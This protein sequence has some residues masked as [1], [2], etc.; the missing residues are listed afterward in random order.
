LFDLDD[1]QQMNK[2]DFG[3]MLKTLHKF[4]FKQDANKDFTEFVDMTWS[5]AGKR[6]D[7]LVSQDAVV[8]LVVS[9][10]LLSSYW[11]LNDVDL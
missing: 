4:Y 6:E 1:D 2:S 5:K 3:K 8:E 10:P 11:N 7:E 9:K